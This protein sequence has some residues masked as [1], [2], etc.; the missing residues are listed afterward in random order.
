[1]IRWLGGEFLVLAPD[2]VELIP[3]VSV[4]VDHWEK[5]SDVSGEYKLHQ[6]YAR[7]IKMFPKARKRSIS[8]AIAISV[9][10]IR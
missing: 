1:M 9:T 2:I 7:T 6:V 8:L 5:Q 4:H 3:A 10:R